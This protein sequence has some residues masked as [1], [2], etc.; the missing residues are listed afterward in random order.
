MKRFFILITILG[1]LSTTAVAQ[2]RVINDVKRTLSSLNLSVTSYKGAMSKLTPALKHQET[3]N[4]AE[5]WELAGKIQM[6]MYDKY[7]D[8]MRV[9]QKVDTVAMGK[10]LIDAY[11]YY[12]KAMRL[13]TIH[14]I[15]HD[16]LVKVDRR[17]GHAKFRTK[18][19]KN[20][21]RAL[22][23]HLDDYKTVGGDLYNVKSWDKAHR[24]W[25]IYCILAQRLKGTKQQVS[26]QQ[27]GEI[28]YYQGIAL[29]QQG[30]NASAARS[31]AK[32]MQ[33]GFHDKEVYDYALICLSNAGDEGGI[34]KIAGEAFK[35]FGTTDPQYIRILINDLI[36]RKS[37]DQAN[38]L[39]D[40]AIGAN[41]HDAELQNLKGLVVEQQE[42]IEAALP[43]YERCIEL[44][45]NDDRG[46]FNVGRYYYNEA[47]AE[48]DRNSRMSMRVL[49][50]RVNPL[51]KKALPYIEKSY[52]LNPENK[53][54]RDALRNIYYRLGQGDKL[55]SLE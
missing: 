22:A 17:T 41:D 42:G 34:V 44:N 31:F 3:A 26:D 9:G 1:A 23:D 49:R 45:P 15:D 35:R 52:Q 13:D 12:D 18:Y 5:T 40:T 36:N 54:A 4:K 39:L 10:S 11:D 30:D 38:R 48:A 2:K 29:W 20:I 55:Q 53:E 21:L 24:A 51:F 33:L 43:Y 19:S 6:G 47:M 32:A 28:R 46:L 7:V 27:V 16:G 8:A 50:E 25:E 37:Y 14:E